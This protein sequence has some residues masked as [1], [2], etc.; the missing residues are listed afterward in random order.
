MGILLYFIKKIVIAICIALVCFS[1]S[2]IPEDPVKASLGE[3]EN[4][5]YFSSGG[6]QDY[7]DYAK[8]YYTTANISENPYLK[9][10][11]EQ[12]LA[13]IALVAIGFSV[14]EHMQNIIMRQFHSALPLPANKNSTVIASR[15]EK[16]PACIFP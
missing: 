3:Y 4:H 15:Q 10:I 13:V 5:V 11:D 12:D 2:S 1:S 16:F 7:T 6:F 9:R 14:R 8:Y